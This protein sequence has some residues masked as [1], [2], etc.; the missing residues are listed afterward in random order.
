[1]C[2]AW[3]RASWDFLSVVPGHSSLKT[4]SR[5]ISFLQALGGGFS[6]H[7]FTSGYIDVTSVGIRQRLN[8]FSEWQSKARANHV[9]LP[10]VSFPRAN[11]SVGVCF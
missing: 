6:H 2:S 10:P 9:E 5:S 11:Q 3:K 7:L 1:M 8:F 4:F